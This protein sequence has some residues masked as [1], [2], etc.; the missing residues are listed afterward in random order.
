[1]RARP[2]PH[3]GVQTTLRYA[4]F[5]LK[6]LAETEEDLRQK[7]IPFHL[8][9]AAEPRGELLVVGRL[10]GVRLLSDPPF[11]AFDAVAERARTE[12]RRDSMSPPILSFAVLYLA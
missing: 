11:S 5:M 8:L 1:M 7:R 12:G 6:G 10:L 9:Q 2:A 3:T 4:G